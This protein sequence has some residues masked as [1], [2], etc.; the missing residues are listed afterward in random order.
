MVINEE[1]R[2]KVIPIA[3]GKGG[4]GKSFLAANIAVALSYTGARTLLVDL[5]LGNS[6]L[7][8]FLGLKNIYPGIGNFIVS[9][10]FKF[11]DIIVQTDFTNLWFVPGDVFVTGMADLQPV[12][13]RKILKE[14]L[15]MDAD[16]IVLDIAPGSNLQ[17][18]DFFLISNSGFLVTTPVTTS[19]L[20][21]FNFLKNSVIA[22]LSKAFS[23]NQKFITY[24]RRIVKEKDAGDF[25]AMHEILK[26]VKKIDLKIHTKIVKYLNAFQPKFIINMADTPDDIYNVKKLHDLVY[27]NLMIDIEC[28]GLIYKDDV[29]DESLEELVNVY[30]RMPDSLI[31]REVERIAQ[32][33]LQS[34]D[35]PRMPLDLNYYSDSYELAKIEAENDFEEISASKPVDE[36][37]DVGELMAVIREQKKQ[38]NELRGTIRMLTLKND[39]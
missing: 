3:S 27:D 31:A 2:R 9:K 5:A 6:N 14:I 33:I 30:G 26:D 34:P 23:K 11:K 36:R 1:N 12:Q 15:E 13:R 38:I 8:S 24:L 21:T 22:L 29:V 32:K 28:M 37:F 17:N 7:H 19:L 4:V 35:F 25:P 20:S 18:I 10:K 39:F 16:Y